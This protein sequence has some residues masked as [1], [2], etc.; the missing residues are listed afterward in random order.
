MKKRKALAQT[1]EDHLSI[2][3][4]KATAAEL[5]FLPD[6]ILRMTAGKMHCF[7]INC[8]TFDR[9]C[10]VSTNLNK[11]FSKCVSE[12]EH[13][14]LCQCC[15]EKCQAALKLPCWKELCFLAR[16]ARATEI[17]KVK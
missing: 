2:K 7:T 1:D 4:P 8:W 5:I 16:G 17:N 12:P 6:P 14:Y 11:I 13:T 9:L 3:K 15:V 10:Y